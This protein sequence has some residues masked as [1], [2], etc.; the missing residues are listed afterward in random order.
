MDSQICGTTMDSSLV[1]HYH[2]HRQLRGSHNKSMPFVVVLF[3]FLLCGALLPTAS[4]NVFNANKVQ[5]FGATL[6]NKVQSNGK[7]QHVTCADV[8]GMT[9]CT[10]W[11]SKRQCEG[12]QQKCKNRAAN[13]VVTLHLTA[14]SKPPVH[15]AAADPGC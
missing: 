15:L 4:T 11:M 13:E 6:A 2:E 9:N 1:A 14:A 10:R 7:E 3:F 5:L 8:L 12:L